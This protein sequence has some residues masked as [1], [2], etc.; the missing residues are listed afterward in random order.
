MTSAL[1]HHIRRNVIAYLALFVALGGT[2][3]AAFSV[4]AN[5]V[6]PNQIRNHSISPVKL[7]RGRFGAYVRYWAQIAP[8][9][10]LAGGWPHGAYVS[11]SSAYDTGLLGW[12]APIASGCFPVA[13]GNDG[14]VETSVGPAPGHPR[15]ISIGFSVMNAA[16]Q[17]DPN[18]GV[19]IAV[20]CPQP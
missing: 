13:S 6:G 3:Y 11:W 20:L 8:G 4:P 17:P 7:N 15:S 1:L 18:E 14:F 12:R 19:F 2:S 5:S 10:R 9:G 16:G